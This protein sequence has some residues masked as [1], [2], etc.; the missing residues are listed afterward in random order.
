MERDKLKVSSLV[1]KQWMRTPG[2]KVGCAQPW[3]SVTIAEES[4]CGLNKE[5]AKS[6]PI[7][8]CVFFPLGLIK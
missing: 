3:E 2:S 5:V 8:V 6:T 1:C 7:P 4:V